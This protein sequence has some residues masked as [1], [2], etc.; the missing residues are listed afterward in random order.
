MT[1]TKPPGTTTTLK[2]PHS[3]NYGGLVPLL[4]TFTP[5]DS[6]E[7]SWVYD[8]ETEGTVWKD[9]QYNTDYP[10]DCQPF[11][12]QNSVYRPGICP[13]G[14]DFASLD[15]TVESGG[16]SSSQ[17]PSWYVGYCCSTGYTLSFR[18]HFYEHPECFS[19]LMPP[20]VATV[21]DELASDDEFSDPVT[22]TI[23]S[24]L[25]AIEEPVQ[26]VWCESDL[27]YFPA[28]V[29]N[30]FRALMGLAPLTTTTGSM[31][32]ATSTL[33]SFPLSTSTL[34]NFPLSTSTT[35]PEY[36]GQ[37]GVDTSKN[38]S[39]LSGGAIAGICVGAVVFLVLLVS[40]F[41]LACVRRRRKKLAQRDPGTLENAASCHAKKPDEG[42]HTTWWRPW[43]KMTSERVGLGISTNGENGIRMAELHDTQ[44]GSRANPIYV[45]QRHGE[46]QGT[47]VAMD[48]HGPV[49]LEGQPL[50][51]SG[52]GTTT[53]G[54]SLVQGNN[55]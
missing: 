38:A 22:T 28:P 30:S 44:M 3:D 21:T 55:P 46:L 36:S 23:G 33:S 4:T 50:E 45:S 24:A 49:E 2:G 16:D 47:T 39:T 42:D 37:D 5:P 20:I 25:V 41:C 34:S 17:A 35:T 7:N 14:Q 15:V 26:I 27:T 32:S 29:A 9:R 10:V 53:Q 19:G 54:A 51:P 13:S 18:E 52:L 11:H 6:C 8:V 43:K 48:P 40:G 12:G 31:A 1:T